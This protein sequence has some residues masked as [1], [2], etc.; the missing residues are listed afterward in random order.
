M[1][2]LDKDEPLRQKTVS[3]SLAAWSC[4]GGL[5]AGYFGNGCAT[6]AGRPGFLP[7]AGR[8]PGDVV[9]RVLC[10]E[11]VLRACRATAVVSARSRHQIRR[12]RAGHDASAGCSAHA[13]YSAH[14]VSEVRAA[15]RRCTSAVSFGAELH[16]A[17]LIRG[18]DRRSVPFSRHSFRTFRSPFPESHEN[19]SLNFLQFST[20]NIA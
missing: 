20:H 14:S 10:S 3:R 12:L 17:H 11:S 2:L 4:S 5:A 18:A 1:L 7:D 6:V 15:L 9:R 16:S 19:Q 13:D 8:T